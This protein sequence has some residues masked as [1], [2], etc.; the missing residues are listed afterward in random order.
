M[1]QKRRRS[2]RQS[3]EESSDSDSSWSQ[4][5][6]EWTPKQ[7]KP[8]SAA[9]WLGRL[10]SLAPPAAPTSPPASVSPPFTPTNLEELIRLANHNDIETFRDCRALKSMLPHLQ[11]LASLVG[12]ASVKQAVFDL[13][14]SN[15][16]RDLPRSELNH[17]VVYGL[18]GLGKTTL[19]NILAKVMCSLSLVDKAKVVHATAASMIAGFLGQTAEKT[20]ALVE[21]AAGGV[22][23]IDEA[24]SL[25]DGRSHN[26]DS[27]SKSAVDTLN[28]LLTEKGSQFVCILAG[29]E[30]EIE[31]DF[32][33]INPGLRRRFPHVFRLSKYS[34]LE[35]RDIAVYHLAKTGLQVPEVAVQC[36]LFSG[37]NYDYFSSMAGDVTVLVGKIL[38]AHSRTVF[39]CAEKKKI[40]AATVNQGFKDFLLLKHRPRSDSVLHQMYV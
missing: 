35:L 20:T 10:R 12:L 18:P 2:K 38:A 40:S 31:R 4:S 9:R 5:D 26:G 39:G 6:E 30:D 36:S 33:S 27:F 21:S 14:L 17:M 24:S 19:V 8:S 15:L 28:R 22:L 16:Q 3:S 29:Y 11:D 32:F 13:I 37:E 23:L 34:P 1:N 25:A 7:K